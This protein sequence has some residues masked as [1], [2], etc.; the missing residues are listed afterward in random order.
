MEVDI[1]LNQYCNRKGRRL[2]LTK[3]VS[4]ERKENK[5]IGG[6]VESGNI[7]FCR[8]LVSQRSLCF[9]LL[10]LFWTQ[11]SQKLSDFLEFS[12]NNFQIPPLL[13]ILYFLKAF[14][15]TTWW[16]HLRNILNLSDLSLISRSN[17]KK[18]SKR[19]SSCL[20]L[21]GIIKKEWNYSINFQH[22]KINV[23]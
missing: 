13:Q 4:R 20:N 5:E 6:D 9:F 2:Y 18:T 21:E 10:F 8:V 14:Y 23:A 22:L 7:R 16:V 19:N 1:L 11:V 12:V 15:V 3:F 17:D